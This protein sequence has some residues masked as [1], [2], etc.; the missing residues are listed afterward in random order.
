MFSIQSFLAWQ[1]RLIMSYKHLSQ[2]ERYQM[3]SLRKAVND[4][5][6]TAKLQL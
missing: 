4:P 1:S 2:S 5:F 3:Y 6:Q